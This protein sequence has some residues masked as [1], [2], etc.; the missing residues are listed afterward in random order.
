[1][2]SLKK[3]IKVLLAED[4]RFISL[5][6]KD[7][8][9]RAGFK[10]FHAL[11]GK[12]AL[13]LAKK[14]LP[15]IIMLDIIMPEMNGFEALEALKKDKSTKKI[16]VVVLSNLGQESDIKKAQE[17]GATDYLV[18]SN[19]SLSEVIEKINKILN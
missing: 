4:D 12:N 7:G 3:E 17:L 18:K 1:M 19:F 16:P 8:L 10:V 9:S 5:A 14:E 6:Y 15:D 11:D 2:G 13:E